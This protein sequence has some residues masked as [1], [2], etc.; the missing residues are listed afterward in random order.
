ML[1]LL[2][3]A[4]VVEMLLSQILLSFS[5][6]RASIANGTCTL[7]PYNNILEE[8][9]KHQHGTTL[10]FGDFIVFED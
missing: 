1:L 9:M 3:E 2:T 8:V 4:V 10:G 5:L 7:W 6:N